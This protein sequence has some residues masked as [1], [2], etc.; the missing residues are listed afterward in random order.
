MPMGA[1]TDRAGPGSGEIAAEI[2]QQ[3]EKAD[4]VNKETLTPETG[5]ADGGGNRNQA[6]VAETE[7]LVKD[8]EGNVPQSGGA[9][10]V[11]PQMSAPA[12]R[13][14]PGD[15][16]KRAEIAPKPKPRGQPADIVPVQTQT[17]AAT[18]R[19]A[20]GR[21]E[22]CTEI[23]PQ[24]K[25]A[26]GT[27]EGTS[28]PVKGGAESGRKRKKPEATKQETP[29]EGGVEAKP[30]RKRT[31]VAK[32]E[33]PVEVGAIEGGTEGGGVEEVNV[34]PPKRRRSTRIK[35]TKGGSFQ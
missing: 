34:G 21:G 35:N 29:V 12:E 10:S 5:G 24:R 6:E 31:S 11:P 19:A 23:E 26:D 3:P 33:I 4:V 32:K 25:T 14:V 15:A 13:V 28:T 30:K 17:S 16:V 2:E 1:R 18:G 8:G 7:T 22:I 9:S 27:K 20:R